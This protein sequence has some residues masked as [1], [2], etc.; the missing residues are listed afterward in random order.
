M[1]EGLTLVVGGRK[2]A[3]RLMLA[4][5]APRLVRLRARSAPPTTSGIERL[6]QTHGLGPRLTLLAHRLVPSST[7]MREWC[8][9]ARRG[10]PG[11]ALAYLWRPF[12]LMW[13]LPRGAAVWAGAVA[14]RE[15]RARIPAFL[16]GGRWALGAWWRCRAQ[17]RRGGLNSVEIS[18]PPSERAGARNGVERVLSRV[19]A[20]CLERSLVRQCWH[21]AH[22]RPRDVVIGVRGTAPNFEAHAWLDGDSEGAEAF[23]EIT[24][25]PAP[26]RR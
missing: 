4:D 12:W 20:S 22:G 11:L 2:L 26:P 7:F 21:A 9:L 24:R 19:H 25:W 23:T 5:D 14:P 8:P 18:M 13:K 10:M 15:R 16:A 17:L 3:D 6:I 1:R